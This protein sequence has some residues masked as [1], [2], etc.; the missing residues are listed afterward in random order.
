MKDDGLGTIGHLVGHF[1]PSVAGETVHIDT[2]LLDEF[3]LLGVADPVFV[4]I[5]ELLRLVVL[6]G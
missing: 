2:C 1:T 4:F 6:R 5:R 3:H